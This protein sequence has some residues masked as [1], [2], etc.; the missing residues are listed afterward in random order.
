MAAAGVDGSNT[1]E[2]GGWL[3]LPHDP[4]A[5]CRDSCTRPSRRGTASSLGV[6]LTR[7]GRPALAGGP[8][9]LRAGGARAATSLDDL[10]GGI[11]ADGKPLEVTTRA[12]SPMR[13]PPR[14]TWS[15]AR[16]P[17]VPA[18]VRAR[19][20][21]AVTSSSTRP[22]ERHPGGRDLVRTGPGDWFGYGRVEAVRAALGVEPGSAL[23]RG[24][25]HRHPSAGDTRQTAMSRAVRA[26]PAR[27]PRRAPPT[28]ARQR[29][30]RRRHPVR[31]RAAHRA[32][33]GR[34]VV[35]LAGASRPPAPTALGVVTVSASAV[36]RPDPIRF[37]ACAP[38]RDVAPV[39][40]APSVA[41]TL[42]V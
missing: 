20:L 22:P 36:A 29:H 17:A 12:T 19:R 35:R 23:A 16:W 25:R 3:L 8:G 27:V 39:R 26:C 15:R 41:T 2:R 42:P 38:V 32:A 10:R 4:D 21:A 18:A 7:H 24:G 34:P 9:R 33:A 14:P 37:A 31:A 28:S 11:D 40:S 30:A 5:V 1:G 13:S 6:V